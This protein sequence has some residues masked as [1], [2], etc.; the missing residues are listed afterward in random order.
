MSF[1]PNKTWGGDWGG[2]KSQPRTRHTREPDSTHNELKHTTTLGVPHTNK[3][4]PSC[5]P[6]STRDTPMALAHGH[7]STR[8]GGPTRWGPNG[9]THSQETRRHT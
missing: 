1:L 9:D 5:S 8:W 7:V 3:G 2:Q 6:G 4:S